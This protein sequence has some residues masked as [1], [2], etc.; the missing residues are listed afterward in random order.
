M[1]EGEA[2]MFRDPEQAELELKMHN[3]IKKFPEEVQQRFM[4]VKVL[5]DQTGD[6]EDEQE[7][8]F[9]ALELKYEK[10]YQE[11]YEKRFQVINGKAENDPK[12]VEEFDARAELLQDDKFKELEVDICD[13]SGIQNTPSGVSGFF[14]K[15]MLANGSIGST[16]TEKDRPILGYLENIKLDL[17]EEGFGFDLTFVF[18]SNSYFKNTELKKSFFL[19]RENVIEKCVGTTIEWNDGCDPTHAKKKKKVK[20]GKNKKTVTTTVKCESFFNFFETL[21]SEK[22]ETKDKEEA[23]E[24][25]DEDDSDANE[26]DDIGEKMDKDF[27]LGTIFK[28][29]LIPLAL[30]YYLGVIDDDDDMDDDDDDDDSGDDDGGGKKKKSN[31][32]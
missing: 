9:R 14:M 26:E 31:K 21:E 19:A 24:K 6:I 29:D 28:E 25:K 5:Y 3:M 20:S 30:E 13:V 2:Q 15:A 18:E 17:H 10:K 7:K 23:A 1:A 11:I 27:D 8:E 32:K 12:L 4:A 16:I 22:K